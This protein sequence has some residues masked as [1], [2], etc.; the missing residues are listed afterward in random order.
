MKLDIRVEKPNT[1]TVQFRI[2]PDTNTM[3]TKLRHHY[4]VTNGR[5]IKQ[6]IRQCYETVYWE[7]GEKK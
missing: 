6:M 7:T 1:Q 2:D 5:I 4:G 3:L